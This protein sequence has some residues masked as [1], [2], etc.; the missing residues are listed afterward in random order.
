MVSVIGINPL[1]NK[2]SNNLRVFSPDYATINQGIRVYAGDAI[3]FDLQTP[4]NDAAATAF[5]LIQV[6]PSTGVET[7][8]ITMKF[9]A[10][11]Q[12]SMVISITT[13]DATTG[14]VAYTTNYR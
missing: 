3:H 2:G 11:W 8:Q 1:I 6:N 10:K 7:T 12:R 5:D 13:I 9:T 14:V 4:C